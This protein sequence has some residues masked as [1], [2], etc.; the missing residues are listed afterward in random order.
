VRNK[1][2][3]PEEPLLDNSSSLITVPEEFLLLTARLP[4]D[5]NAA[6]VIDL[7]T[8]RIGIDYAMSGAALMELSL[9]DKLETD[10]EHLWLLDT[11]PTGNIAVDAVLAKLSSM[12]CDLGTRIPIGDAIK[13][14]ESINAYQLALDALKARNAVTLRSKRFLWLFTE[15]TLEVVDP[16]L[17]PSIRRRIGEVL[18][19][20]AIPDPR[21]A[22]LLSLTEATKK[23]MRVVDPARTQEAIRNSKNY[24]SLDLV[25]RNVA[26]HVSR[27]IESL[28]KYGNIV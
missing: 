3:Y 2:A 26:L 9:R 25:G 6:A 19:E 23:F 8:S 20:A 28:G 18:F 4:A 14:L 21:D 7:P 24:V 11:T 1:T 13:E 12:P 17:V 16:D 15:R 22:C 5:K 27:M 10:V